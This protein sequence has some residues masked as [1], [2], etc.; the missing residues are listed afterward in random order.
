MAIILTLLSVLVRISIDF[1]LI[2]LRFNSLDLPR[3]DPDPLRYIFDK[4]LVP[5]IL[6]LVFPTFTVNIGLLQSRRGH[7]QPRLEIDYPMMYMPS[8]YDFRVR[9]YD[10]SSLQLPCL[11]L[12][13]VPRSRNKNASAQTT[14]THLLASRPRNVLDI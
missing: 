10:H 13:R 6:H 3:S 7:R 12:D 14:E 2:R 5:P 4:N 1:V 8:L 9:F 11:I